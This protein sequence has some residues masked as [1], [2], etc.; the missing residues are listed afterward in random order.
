M[1]KIKMTLV[2]LAMGFASLI[3]A[4]EITKDSL[5]I[6]EFENKLKGMD[7]P[8]EYDVYAKAFIQFNENNR[9]KDVRVECENYQLAN[10]IKTRL[11]HEKIVSTMLDENKVYVLPIKILS[12]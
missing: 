9:I 4:Q 2:I 6:N 3:S 1:K 8:I 7:F 5:A 12:K 10:F 11:I